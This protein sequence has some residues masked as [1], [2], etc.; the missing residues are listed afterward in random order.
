[1][2]VQL[3]EKGLIGIEVYYALHSKEE[4]AYLTALAREYSLLPSGGSDFHGS[5]KPDIQIGTGHGNLQ[6]PYSILENLR[7]HKIHSEF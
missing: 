5:N 7:R 2:I 3:K 1:M 4:E 6:I